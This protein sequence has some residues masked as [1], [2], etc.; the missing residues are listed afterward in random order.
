MKLLLNDLINVNYTTNKHTHKKKV[1]CFLRLETSWFW[2]KIRCSFTFN[3]VISPRLKIHLINPVPNLITRKARLISQPFYCFIFNDRLIK[4]LFQCYLVRENNPNNFQIC[5]RCLK[6]KTSK[7]SNLG[8]LEVDYSESNVLFICYQW[9]NDVVF[10][11][12][13]SVK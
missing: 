6:Y 1:I 7:I 3:A 5:N 11:Q 4:H 9:E 8:A 13:S 2:Y 12:I 10:I